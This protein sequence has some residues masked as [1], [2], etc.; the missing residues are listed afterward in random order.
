M[1]GHRTNPIALA[2]GV[3]TVVLG[4]V[5]FALTT[6]PAGAWLGGVAF[7]A[8]L[9]FEAA[10][11]AFSH[12]P[13][14][15]VLELTDSETEGEDRLLSFS[16]PLMLNVMLWWSTPLIITSVL[17]RTPE[18]D[19]SI[20]AFTVVDARWHGSSP[21]RWGSYSTLPSPWSTAKPRAKRSVDMQRPWL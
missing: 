12:A 16:A 20:A 10:I 11:V 7:T 1:G 15:A 13:L 4:A 17:A 8:G 21:R 14:P 18:P 9:A 6:T 19:C 3:R 5:A 2:T